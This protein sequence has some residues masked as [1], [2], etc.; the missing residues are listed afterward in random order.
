MIM[1]SL[2]TLLAVQRTL[3]GRFDRLNI[4]KQSKFFAKVLGNIKSKEEALEFVSEVSE[5]KASHSCW[6]FTL[7]DG[8]SRFSDDGEPSG[9]AGK[10]IL[11]A[12]EGEQITNCVCVVVRYFGGTKLGL[13]GM[14]RAYSGA[15]RDCI[16]N[17]IEENNS[18]NQNIIELVPKAKISLIGSYSDAGIIYQLINESEKRQNLT[19]LGEESTDYGELQVDIHID[20]ISD[21]AISSL[22]ERC[23]DLGA[24]R[25]KMKVDYDPE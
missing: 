17:A 18:E 16:R 15:C 1:F 2:F 25:I 5:S 10:P 13:G 7:S 9:A 11:L 8:Y 24:G 22:Q 21:D 23:D 20:L 12:I 14:S 4:V 19:R 6:A 3:N